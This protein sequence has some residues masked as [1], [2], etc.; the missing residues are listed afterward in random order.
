MATPSAK[1]I[2]NAIHAKADPGIAAQFRRF[3]KTADGEYGAGEQFLGVRVPDLRR[4][5]REFRE[6]SLRVIAGF[7]RSRWHEERL[8]AVI[9]MVEK[10]A[11]GDASIREAIHRLYCDNLRFI[12]NWDIVDA[13]APRI[14]GPH[15]EKRDRSQ[16]R[17]WA[18]SSNLWERRIAIMATF[19]FIRRND[20]DDT[21]ALAETLLHDPEDLIHKAVGWMLREIG[22][23]DR[24]VVE[25][26]LERHAGVMPRTMLRYAIEKFP[27]RERRAWLARR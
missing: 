25:A 6:A 10:H 15:L 8:F 11:R 4:I 14:V 22:N 21:L 12:N 27:E 1:E 16:L 7:L 2:R 23:R 9:L 19:H 24:A 17:I 3:F 18:K 26:F 13:S 20:F 5:A